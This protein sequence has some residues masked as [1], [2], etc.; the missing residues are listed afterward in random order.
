MLEASE[1][2][3]LHLYNPIWDQVQF[4]TS[5]QSEQEQKEMA[6]CI[7]PHLALCWLKGNVVVP[8]PGI[9]TL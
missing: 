9:E 5:I 7:K 2:V 8:E 1:L 4:K 3:S 6:I